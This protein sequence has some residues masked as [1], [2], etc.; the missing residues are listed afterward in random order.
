MRVR[1][2]RVGKEMPWA[3]I[4]EEYVIDERGGFYL[5][6]ERPLHYIYRNDLILLLNGGWLEEVKEEKTLA[7]KMMGCKPYNELAEI[8]RQHYLE[9]FDKVAG[10]HGFKSMHTYVTL[11]KIFEEGK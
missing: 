4:G 1:K 10:E 9:R 7:E 11:R 5:G 8:A 2:V 6:V 3:N